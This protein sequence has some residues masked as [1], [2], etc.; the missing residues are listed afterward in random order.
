M[1]IKRLPF[2]D[3]GSVFIKKGVKRPLVCFGI[4]WVP[5]ARRLPHFPLNFYTKKPRLTVQFTLALETI[6]CACLEFYLDKV[7]NIKPV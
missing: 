5:H 7:K 3:A 2:V 6:I 4:A 1:I